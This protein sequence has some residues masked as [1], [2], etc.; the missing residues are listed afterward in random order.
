M[1]EVTQLQ[2]DNILSAKAMWLKI[3]AKNV[4]PDLCT[5]R[6]LSEKN[7]FKA[8]DCDTVACFG[9]WC[10]WNPEFIA[11]GIQTSAGGAPFFNDQK[12]LQQGEE[13]CYRLFGDV[14]LFAARSTN[15]VDKSTAR[16]NA[17]AYKAMSDWQLVMNRIDHLI[18]N[19]IV[20]L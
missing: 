2:R 16:R 18:A 5:W 20:T 15:P 12:H 10:A 7:K 19:S 14:A 9:G 8:P 4:V 11:Q 17:K 1:I 13:V 3:P 6:A